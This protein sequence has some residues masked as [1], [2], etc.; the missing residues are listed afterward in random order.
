MPASILTRQPPPPAKNP[1]LTSDRK[2]TIGEE[3]LFERFYNRIRL[4]AGEGGEINSADRE[5][6]ASFGEEKWRAKFLLKRQIDLEEV[7]DTLFTYFST[8][9][10]LQDMS[11]VFKFWFSGAGQ[12]PNAAVSGGGGVQGGRAEHRAQRGDLPRGAQQ[13]GGLRTTHVQRLRHRPD[14]DGHLPGLLQVTCVHTC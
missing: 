8:L 3:I 10:Q 4:V 12:M 11:Q 7:Q 6:F 5:A 1:F 2:A 9:F 14:R 13:D